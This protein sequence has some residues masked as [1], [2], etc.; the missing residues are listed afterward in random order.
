ME[1][2]QQ[3]EGAIRVEVEGWLVGLIALAADGREAFD[4]RRELFEVVE[5]L[6]LPFGNSP[7]PSTPPRRRI[8]LHVA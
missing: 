4:E 5:A 6:E 7:G 8:E 2:V 3:E 1:H